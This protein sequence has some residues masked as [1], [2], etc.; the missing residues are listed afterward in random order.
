MKYNIFTEEDDL[1]IGSILVSDEVSFI[2]ACK[3]FFNYPRNDRYNGNLNFF[4]GKQL[5]HKNLSNIKI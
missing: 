5:V 1:Y 3:L 4:D 2:D